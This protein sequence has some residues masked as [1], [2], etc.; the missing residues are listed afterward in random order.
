ME[1]SASYSHR[2]GARPALFVYAGLPGEPAFG[3]PAF[4]HRMSIMDSPEA[5]ISHHWLDSTHITFG[6]VTAGLVFGDVKL[7]G[8]ALQRPRARP[9][10]LEH[11]DRAARF[12]RRA[13]VLE[14][15][16]A[17]SRCR[18]AG[19]ISSAPSS[20]SRTRIRTRWSASAIYTRRFGGDAMVVD[21][22]RLG[23]ARRRR[24]LRRSKA[25]PGSACG[26][27]SA[28]PRSTEN[29]EL[30]FAGGHHGPRY[31]VGKVSLGAIRDFRVA[32]QR[33]AR[34]RRPICAE[35]RP[36]RARGAL[37]RQPE[38]RDGVHP[39]EDRLTGPPERAK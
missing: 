30:T 8:V 9:A 7:E 24:R 34:P 29:D 35:L 22:A 32:P 18:R 36:R 39:A 23:P 12:D 6:V 25:P 4:M 28:A 37:W 17:T 13:P 27:C 26:P 20:S 19:R 5:P 10:S 33:P 16:A 15:D 2:F 31:T 38:R 11:R 1:L 21:D 14:P 3:P